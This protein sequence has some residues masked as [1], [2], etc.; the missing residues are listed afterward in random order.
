VE[1]GRV[2]HTLRPGVDIVVE[3]QLVVIL[4]QFPY[5]LCFLLVSCTT[6][7]FLR[8]VFP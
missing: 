7:L 8:I 1:A 5:P 4:K 6:L 2:S 3:G